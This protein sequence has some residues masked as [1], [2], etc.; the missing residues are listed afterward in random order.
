[1]SVHALKY[2]GFISAFKSAKSKEEEVAAIL[3]AFSAGKA[4]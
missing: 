3:D 1:M 2:S 4:L